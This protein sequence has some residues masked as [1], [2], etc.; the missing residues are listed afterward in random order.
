MASMIDNLF[1]SHVIY[2][3]TD[4]LTF[5]SISKRLSGQAKDFLWHHRFYKP[6]FV[7]SNKSHSNTFTLNMLRQI[8]LKSCHSSITQP[9]MGWS[10][11]KSSML[12]FSSTIFLPSTTLLP[13]L[14]FKSITV[15]NLQ[16]ATCHCYHSHGDGPL[17]HTRKLLHAQISA[18]QKSEDPSSLINQTNVIRRG[19]P[20]QRHWKNQ[21]HSH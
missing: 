14:S 2:D 1:L 13:L 18:V 6:S 19:L 3:W 7:S 10:S 9:K 17:G 21:T 20:N 11:F 8:S 15:A 12:R 5:P 16:Y 4:P